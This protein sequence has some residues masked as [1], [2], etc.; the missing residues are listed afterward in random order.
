MLSPRQ[1][2][3]YRRA[4]RSLLRP[5]VRDLVAKGVTYPALDQILRELFVEIAERDF[6]LP[7]KSPSDSRVSLV[8]GLHRKEVARLRHR[9]PDLGPQMSAVE[10]IASRVIGRWL[11][12][13]SCTDARGRPRAIAYEEKGARGPSFVGLV[14]ELGI[15]VPAR[16][17]LDELVRVGAVELLP[18]G[19]LRLREEALIPSGDFESKLPVLAS[20]PAELFS[21]IAHNLDDPETPWLQRKV[22]Y[23]NVGAEAL[24]ELREAAKAIGTEFMRTANALLASRDRDRNPRAPGGRRSRVVLGAYYFE[25]GSEPAVPSAETE[26]EPA[27]RARR[28]SREP[29]PRKRPAKRSS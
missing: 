2:E 15:D 10:S 29:R 26:A 4:I 16:S 5:I 21:T 8:T 14:R 19:D 20:D 1:R 6:A 22:V 7:F 9:K 25:S 13:R 28:A 3:S 17:V 11:A 23:D 12:K 27:P 18:S 24:P